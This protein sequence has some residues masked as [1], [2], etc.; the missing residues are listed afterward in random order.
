MASV[1]GDVNERVRARL[2]GISLQSRQLQGG[3][4]VGWD[5]PNPQRGQWLR[6][7]AEARGYHTIEE[8]A[9]AVGASR[10]VVSGW[11][12]GSPVGRAEHRAALVG[13]LGPLM[14]GGGI[15]ESDRA[16]LLR[17]IGELAGIASRLTELP[18]TASVGDPN[19][20]KLIAAAAESKDA[21]APPVQSQADKSL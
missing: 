7:Q 18:V 1:Q 11:F 3:L 14:S 5:R 8:L 13:I 9:A 4:M 17:I 10:Q 16:A 21:G 2:G 15:A 20:A 19:R 12:D 6:R